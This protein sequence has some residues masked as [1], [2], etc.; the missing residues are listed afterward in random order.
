MLVD[1]LVVER[2]VVVSLVDVG[3]RDVVEG[4]QQPSGN[5]S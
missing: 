5:S 4:S 3:A 1:V 2:E